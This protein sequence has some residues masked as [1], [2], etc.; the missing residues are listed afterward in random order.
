MILSVLQVLLDPLAVFC[1][2]L[3]QSLQ[4]DEIAPHCLLDFPGVERIYPP[5]VDQL[6]AVSVFSHALI[7]H[8]LYFTRGYPC[9]DDPDAVLVQEYHGA[10]RDSLDLTLPRVTE[11]GSDAVG[12]HV[13]MRVHIV[14]LVGV[15]DE[16]P[17][18]AD[19]MFIIGDHFG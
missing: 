9:P 17:W 10:F 15:E 2:H 3:N 7:L 19:R 1:G 11:R 14:A 4:K 18:P 13:E 6:L 5:V 8:F 16:E 12:H